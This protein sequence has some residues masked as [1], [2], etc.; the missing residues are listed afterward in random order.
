MNKRRKKVLCIALL[1]IS[2]V[3]N[4]LI[5]TFAND[6]NYNNLEQITTVKDE[7]K[8]QLDQSD[9]TQKTDLENSNTN[10]DDAQNLKAEESNQ[11]SD[12]SL[13]KNDKEESSSLELEKE[14]KAIENQIKDPPNSLE[15]ISNI[16]IEPSKNKVNLNEKFYYKVFYEIQNNTEN[17][18]ELIIN[19]S[20]NLEILNKEQLKGAEIIGNKIS[21]KL[22]T[23][24]KNMISNF[25]NIEVKFKDGSSKDSIATS[26]AILKSNEEKQVISSET[27]L[28]RMTLAKLS[29][30]FDKK[31]VIGNEEFNYRLNYKIKDSNDPTKIILN[32]PTNLV[33]IVS[34]TENDD[35]LNK[36]IIDTG[37]EFY[38]KPGN[39]LNNSITVKLKFKDSALNESNIKIVSKVID[40]DDALIEEN[41]S[42]YVELVKPLLNFT[43]KANKDI[44][45][46]AEEFNY[47]INY[48][49]IDANQDTATI[50]VNIPD[51]LEVVSFINKDKNIIDQKYENN[52]IVYKLNTKDINKI[53][54]SLKVKVRFKKDMKDGSRA[55]VSASVNYPSEYNISSKPVILNAFSVVDANIITTAEKVSKDEEFA[56]I[57]NFTS[58]GDNKTLK[59]E[60]NISDTL[61]ILSVND[62]G[63]IKP[64]IDKSNN[65]IIFNIPPTSK[66]ISEQFEIK[67]KF[68][69]NE[70]NGSIGNI[71]SS[72][73]KEDVTLVEVNSEDTVL[74]LKPKLEIIKNMISADS[75]APNSIAKY[76]ITVKNKDR[77]NLKDFAIKDIL[78]KEGIFK[79]AVL[80][81]SN[82]SPISGAD[83]TEK[84]GI[85]SVIVPEK[86]T[87]ANLY[88]DITIEF[89]DVAIGSSITNTGEIYDNRGNYINKGSITN[90]V[91][92]KS[93]KGVLSK[94]ST[95]KVNSAG[96]SQGWNLY[97]KNQGQ[98]AFDKFILKDDIPYENNIYIIN[99]G[100][101]E[102]YDSNTKFTMNIATNTGRVI[103]IATLTGDELSVGK[104]VDIRSIL[105]KG[106]YLSKYEVIIENVPI[107]FTYS[108]WSCMRLDGNV[109]NKHK[110]GS[111]I[112]NNEKIKNTATL[113]YIN[114]DINGKVKDSDFFLFKT[115]YTAYTEKNILKRTTGINQTAQYELV[116][117]SPKRDLPK[118]II[119]DVLPDSME[120]V[121]Y[122]IQIK[123]KNGNIVE[124]PL[125]D[126]FKF[127][128]VKE[129]EKE[130]IRWVFSDNLPQGFT[131]S[132]KVN[133]KQVKDTT[134]ISNEMGVSTQNINGEIRGV[135]GVPDNEMDIP[136]NELET[137]ISEPLGYDYDGNGN[138]G[139][140]IYAQSI[141]NYNIS[142]NSGLTSEKYI[143]KNGDINYGT[144]I[145]ANSE[146]VIDYKLKI[147]NTSN[148]E[149]KDLSIIDILPSVGDKNVLTSSD[150]GSLFTPKLIKEFDILINGKKLDKN[151]LT[152]KYSQ[153]SDPERLSITGK[154]G[155]GTWN[156]EIK[157]IS[158]VKSIRFDISDLTIGPQ[159]VLTIEYSMIIPKDTIED[160]YAINSFQSS[161]KDMDNNL[162]Y[163]VES[164]KVI[165]KTPQS[166]PP[167]DKPEPPIDKPEPPVDKPEPPIDKPEPPVDKP[168]PPIDKPEPPVD[169][170][171]LPIDK[172]KPPV[173]KPES[174][175]DKSEPPVDKPESPIDKPKPQSDKEVKSI[176]G[177]DNPNTGDSGM[178]LYFVIGTISLGILIIRMKKHKK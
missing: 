105:N 104:S 56:Y 31:K 127:E 167:I 158:K 119:F 28:S 52:K 33:D 42:S 84:D 2:I 81:D 124:S 38:L 34:I 103:N 89:K 171:E 64:V 114:K 106:E 113:E 13:N 147:K 5:Y 90:P 50:N 86:Y 30:K 80:K 139:G 46:P 20:D 144:S 140:D 68:K 92:E 6:T 173:D 145:V 69:N 11:V 44:I 132:I 49:M 88:L 166:K 41:V 66:P 51:E 32:I 16:R 12:S 61:E 24:D 60:L 174:P 154:I 165:V 55:T 131:I 97:L 70:Q 18:C 141:A 91:Q 159:D 121:N 93:G 83:I 137:D 26:E 96:G 170:P 71:K 110:D 109:R 134:F 169:K 153:S 21:I 122:E 98:V 3:S 4:S 128:K 156:D 85:V 78:P 163:P 148:N 36:K 129:K 17:I 126:N 43:I 67:V 155:E 162:L 23:T 102:N 47:I 177:N 87:E 111:F 117:K 152:I 82:L 53:N 136:I 62:L 77:Y 130:I 79:E 10:Q 161:A 74:E 58:Q 100:K 94:V 178:A 172:P 112:K 75:I 157:D 73:S 7:L 40:V 72:I 149:L 176:Y 35:I 27:V 8:P 135:Y 39:D 116:T 1:I 95:S 25:V 54:G 120:Y 19:I 76:R 29:S 151:K 108:G 143:K 37:I 57:V 9:A 138:I 168:E 45:Q 59:F 48:E 22:D 123:D 115:A 146:D 150:R 133:L 175:I 101:Y 65:K 63:G 99:S 14:N 142:K 107:G 160:I 125:K 15:H 118:P 164:N